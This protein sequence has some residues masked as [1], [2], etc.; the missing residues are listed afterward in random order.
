MS[1][2]FVLYHRPQKIYR[3]EKMFGQLISAKITE[4]IPEKMFW[5]IIFCR[6]AEIIPKFQGPK[7]NLKMAPLH[8]ACMHSRH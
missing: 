3:P 6:F 5:R 1:G 4:P 7:I 2:I 8:L